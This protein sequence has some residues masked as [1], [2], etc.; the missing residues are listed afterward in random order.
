MAR[1]A[2]GP[3]TK[4]GA[5]SVG[6]AIAIIFGWLVGDVAGYEMPDFVLQAWTVVIMAVINEWSRDDTRPKDDNTP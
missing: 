6:G 1:V 3:R 5:V 4:R 2:A